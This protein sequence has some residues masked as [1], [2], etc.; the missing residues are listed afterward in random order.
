M[1]RQKNKEKERIYI[2]WID[3]I[4]FQSLPSRNIHTCNKSLQLTCRYKYIPPRRHDSGCQVTFY[5][6]CVRAGAS[7]FSARHL[8]PSSSTALW[9]FSSGLIIIWR[10]YL[11]GHVR[12]SLL[13]R[14]KF[15]GVL[16]SN[17][18]FYLYFVDNSDA[19]CNFLYAVLQGW[20]T[21]CA[22]LLWCLRIAC[23]SCLVI[24]F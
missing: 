17:I 24:L 15:N 2:N 6:A 22:W 12:C 13:S 1:N 3:Y 18:Y 4:G 21:S 23:K 14:G 19:W 20:K 8:K 16:L 5:G 9:I 7:S 10:S 11:L